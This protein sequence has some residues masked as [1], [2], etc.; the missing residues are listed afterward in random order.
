MKKLLLLYIL[1]FLSLFANIA[2]CHAKTIEIEIDSPLK[3]ALLYFP[4]PPVMR[5]LTHSG[6]PKQFRKAEIKRTINIPGEG[7]SP[8]EQK[9]TIDVKDEKGMKKFVITSSLVIN[10]KDI[11]FKAVGSEFFDLKNTEEVK[12][13]FLFGLEDL[14]GLQRKIRVIHRIG[15]QDLN[16]E[17]FLKTTKGMISNENYELELNGQDRVVD[18]KVRYFLEG[19]GKIGKNDITIS[20]KDI[21]DDNYEISE[22]YGSVTVFTSVRVFD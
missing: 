8:F 19:G 3:A 15:N 1:L 22:K 6:L 18:G 11:S 12:P 7:E 10:G 16:Y 13:S 20:G 17:V 4:S 5:C 2:I 21:K 14:L 9:V